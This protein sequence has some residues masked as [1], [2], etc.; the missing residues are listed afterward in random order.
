MKAGTETAHERPANAP[1]HVT[2]EPAKVTPLAPRAARD[3]LALQR[4][5]GNQ[6]VVRMLQRDLDLA[7]TG[8]RPSPTDALYGSHIE[9]E[10]KQARLD[11]PAIVAARQAAQA[12]APMGGDVKVGD[13]SV[14]VTTTWLHHLIRQIHHR[15]ME[16]LYAERTSDRHRG[17]TPA[18][19]R[20]LA[21]PFLDELRA[22]PYANRFE[23][24]ERRDIEQDVLTLIQL[25]ALG[26]AED[27][28][29]NQNAA[30]PD[31]MDPS[32]TLPN[33]EARA[34]SGG[35]L[36]GKAP[37]CGA[38]AFSNMRQ[39]GANEFLAPFIQGEGGIISLGRYGYD[40]WIRVDG[41][42]KKVEDYHKLE[43]S[44]PRSYLELPAQVTNFNLDIQ[45]GDLVLL[46]NRWGTRADHVMMVKS[47]DR[48][49]GHLE[50]V[51]GNEGDNHPINVGGYELRDNPAPNDATPPKELQKDFKDMS[52]DEKKQL[53]DFQAKHP[54]SVRLHGRFRW[55]L[56]DFETHH[57]EAGKPSD[58]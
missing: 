2:P 30:R 42:W 4:H 52:A 11:L 5:A 3:V 57:Y 22:A 21:K 54:K 33:A 41:K 38:F 50:K 10:V 1:A 56:V 45:P 53:A 13:R 58:A 35:S 8:E 6:A 34:R 40:H 14:Q 31:P 55:S 48:T 17:D 43:R 46:D 51:A 28:H 16:M 9:R 27:E 49:T 36:P 29:A 7:G 15:A 24:K 47:Y 12:T 19:A 26:L 25:E 37:W 18:Q 39:A 44:S 32:K 23:Y 20:A